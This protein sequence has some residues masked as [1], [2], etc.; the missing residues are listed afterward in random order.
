MKRA[1]NNSEFM[2]FAITI[3]AAIV[4]IAAGAAQ[5]CGETKPISFEPIAEETAGGAVTFHPLDVERPD[6]TIERIPDVGDLAREELP[7]DFGEAARDADCRAAE[8]RGLRQRVGRI[9][10]RPRG[11]LRGVAKRVKS[12]RPLRRCG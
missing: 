1:T 7:I 10:A 2:A 5:V 8:R 3:M 6:F 11:R 12:W 9:L 4:A